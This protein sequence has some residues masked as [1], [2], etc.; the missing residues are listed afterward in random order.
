MYKNLLANTFN[1]IILQISLVIV[2][3]GGLVADYFGH[4]Y[5]IA[6]VIAVV[7]ILWAIYDE[8]KTNKVYSAP[9]IPIPIVFNISNPTDSKSA[10]KSLFGILES[11]YPNHKKNLEK[12]FNI[13]ED[14]L[15]FK[16]DGDIFNKERF[17]D[18]LKIT[19]HEIKKLD[20]QIPQNIHYHIVYIGPISTAI[21][22]GTMLGT[23]GV[24]LYQY[25][26]ST[27]SYTIGIELKS[28]AYKE[29]IDEF[30]IVKKN[31]I[32]DMD[33]AKSVTVAIDLASH[34]IALNK[35]QT[36]IVHLESIVGATLHESKDFL[37][38][39]Q[40]IYSV[41]NQLQQHNT[42]ITLVYSMPVTVA[43]MI[44]MSIQ[45]YWDIELT[46]FDNGE[47]RSVIDRLNSIKYYF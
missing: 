19:K 15:V 2:G 46:Q 39:N 20:K 34:K 18:F 22:I 45:N 11:E 40:E 36:P 1:N 13:I 29:H 3:I 17:M 44:G 26:K 35:L 5:W 21:M 16:Y 47:Y 14:D 27:D 24:T 32:G 4:G 7:G 31:I 28:R 30:S 43:I 9:N 8:Y 33:D 10:L 12:Y 38:A 42:H 23:E 25:N 6:I 37:R 41:I